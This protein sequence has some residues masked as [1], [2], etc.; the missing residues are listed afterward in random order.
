MPSTKSFKRRKFMRKNRLIGVIIVLC[1]IIGC[2][3][4][5]TE[6]SY[7]GTATDSQNTQAIADKLSGN[8]P[9]PTD[10]DY[11]LER[12]NLIKRAYWVNGQREKANTLPCEIEKPLG[13][14]VLFT[15][16]GSIINQFVVD[17]KV[18]SLNSFL[19]PDSEYYELNQGEAGT[20][21][22]YNKWLADVDGSYGEN[23]NGIFFF[24]T[25]G[26]YIEWTGV[27]LY[28]DIPFIIDEPVL[29]VGE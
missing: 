1:L 16:S 9:T 14:I 15:E 12:Y 26:K 22:D 8:Q 21:D 23:D 4:G 27:Y 3:I 5:C 7:G 29:K 13:Y 19:S 24:T 6:T 28:S 20:W 10:I 18:S 11:S 17:G 2:L 25:D